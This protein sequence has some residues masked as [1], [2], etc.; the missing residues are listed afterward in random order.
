MACNDPWVQWR[1]QSGI[2]RVSGTNVPSRV[3]TQKTCGILG[4]NPKTLTIKGQTKDHYLSFVISPVTKNTLRGGRQRPKN[5]HYIFYFFTPTDSSGGQDQPASCT[6]GRSFYILQTE[7][8]RKWRSSNKWTH[9]SL[10]LIL[11]SQC[12]V[13]NAYI[14]KL[15]TTRK[16]I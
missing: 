2:F 6:N 5:Y 14:L 9:N 16:N 4:K 1:T 10:T 11:T 8:F 12:S 15:L 3:E 13:F 7:C